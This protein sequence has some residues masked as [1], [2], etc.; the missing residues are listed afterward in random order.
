HLGGAVARLLR[1]RESAAGY[2]QAVAEAAADDERARVARQ[3]QRLQS[4][5]A[6]HVGQRLALAAK[7]VDV[8]VQPGHASQAPREPEQEPASCE[9]ERRELAVLGSPAQLAHLAPVAHGLEL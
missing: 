5:V 6:G 9:P 1:E 7:C 8:A 4:A 3:Q 2:L